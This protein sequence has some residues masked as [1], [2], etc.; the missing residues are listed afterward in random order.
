[1]TLGYSR[2]KSSRDTCPDAE[3]KRCMNW[4]LLTSELILPIGK[5][6]QTLFDCTLISLVN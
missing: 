3:K 4:L 1:M 6:K 2:C 5:R